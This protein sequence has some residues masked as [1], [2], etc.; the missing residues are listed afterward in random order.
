MAHGR[1]AD[2]T[3]QR[4]FHGTFL[5]D[6]VAENPCADL[7]VDNGIQRVLDA[8]V[9]LELVG[10]DLG[11]DLHETLCADRAFGIGIE[12][13]FNGHDRQNQV[14]VQT[15]IE[16]GFIGGTDE[17]VRGRAGNTITLGYPCG[18]TLFLFE[19]VQF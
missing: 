7:D 13:G 16:S 18:D 15:Q 19:L 3:F 17:Q 12:T 6:I 4:Q 11:H 9:V 10:M 14:R 8:A 5:A 2:I 1:C